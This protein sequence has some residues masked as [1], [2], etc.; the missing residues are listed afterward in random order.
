M[1]RVSG[2]PGA[3]LPLLDFDK[4]KADL[5]EKHPF[6]TDRDVMSAALYPQV[7]DEYLT[8]RESFGPVDKLDT[9]I[10]LIGPKVGEEFEV[11]KIYFNFYLTIFYKLV[12]MIR[13]S[14]KVLAWSM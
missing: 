14:C 13:P 12:L 11:R 8:F 10:F 7:T 9:R 3:T 1:P 2:R 4:L 6:S 5:K